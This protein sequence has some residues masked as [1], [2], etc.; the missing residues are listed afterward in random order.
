MATSG[1]KIEIPQVVSWRLNERFS[2]PTDQV[3][4]L[5]CGIVAAPTGQV[6]NTLLGGGGT[7]FLGIN[8]L[9]PASMAGQRNDALMVLEHKGSASSR[10]TTPPAVRATDSPGAVVPNL[11]SQPSG[12]SRGRY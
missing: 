3:L 7:A 1:V 6:Q 11:S 5:S 4:V 9:I 12:V 10:L 8:R 2:W